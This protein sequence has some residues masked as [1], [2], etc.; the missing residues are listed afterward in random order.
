MSGCEIARKK[1]W[2]SCETRL[3]GESIWEI[4]VRNERSVVER[5]DFFCWF[6]AFLV[7][8]L[9]LISSSGRKE[10]SILKGCLAFFMMDVD[11]FSSVFGLSWSWFLT[12]KIQW[13][14]TEE[15]KET[16]WPRQC[17]ILPIGDRDGCEMMDEPR[18]HL[19]FRGV[20]VC[21]HR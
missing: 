1:S 8:F 19:V 13:N 15:K 21:C 14:T 2:C 3:R 16:W 9:G 20:V 10:W 5:L 7:F 11:V 18:C 12:T 4:V 17:A 6:G